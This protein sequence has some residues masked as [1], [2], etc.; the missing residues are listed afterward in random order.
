MQEMIKSLSELYGPAGREEAVAAYI[1]DVM[2]PLAD[3][4]YTDTMG[5]V[6]AV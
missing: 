6:V 1:R 2:S 4:V 3:A 5:C